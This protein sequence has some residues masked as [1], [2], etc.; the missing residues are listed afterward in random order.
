MGRDEGRDAAAVFAPRAFERVRRKAPPA[1]RAQDP[2][3]GRTYHGAADDLR[4][5]FPEMKGLSRRNLFYMRGFAAAWPDPIVQQP[6]AQL[7]WGPRHRAI[8]QGG[9]TRRAILVRSCRR[10]IWLVSERPHEHDDEQVDGADRAAPSNFVQ[11]L[12]APDSELAQQLAKD[13]YSFEFLGE[14]PSRRRTPGRGT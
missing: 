12:V 11:Q 4:A 8:G 13:P 2:G 7:P 5:E 3:P 9:D 1:R 14:S 10:R 6:V